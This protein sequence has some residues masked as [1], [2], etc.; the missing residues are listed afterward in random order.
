MWRN[1]DEMFNIA[2]NMKEAAE[3][4]KETRMII[5]NMANENVNL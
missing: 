2:E 3:E 4:R 1:P 5:E